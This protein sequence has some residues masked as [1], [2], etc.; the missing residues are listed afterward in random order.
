MASLMDDNGRIQC[1]IP[2]LDGKDEGGAPIYWIK[3]PSEWLGEHAQRRDEA[4]ESAR[5]N[6]LGETLRGFAVALALLDDWHLPG[7]G[8]N[9]E[10]WDFTKVSL[11]IIA[12]VSTEINAR[13]WE[14][15]ALPKNS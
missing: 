12:W 4:N 13:Y 10:K 9:P 15:Y 1:H 5:K 3:T 7:L 8:G 14:N 6:K 11:P 2:G